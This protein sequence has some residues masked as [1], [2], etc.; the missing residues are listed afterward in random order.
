MHSQAFFFYSNDLFSFNLYININ[1]RIFKWN[2]FFILLL[3]IYIRVELYPLNYV[4]TTEEK[5]YCFY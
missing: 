4:L 2:F 1:E 3:D 5:I